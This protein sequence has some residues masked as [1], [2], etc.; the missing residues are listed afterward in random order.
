MLA[1]LQACLVL[2]ALVAASAWSA[3][4][5][6][7]GLPLWA[8]LAGLLLTL[9]PHAPVLALEFLLL[10]LLGRDPQAPRASTRQLIRA[11][12][13]EVL[14]GLRVFGWRQPFGAGRQADVPGRPGRAGVL[15]VHGLVCNR[16]LW[17]PWLVQLWRAGVPCI[18]LSLEPAFGRIETWLPAIDA[19]VLRLQRETGRPPLLV[20]HSMGGLVLR[21][22]L[23]A[24]TDAAAADARVLGLIT[25]GTPHHGTWMAR[26]GLSS[27]ARQMRLGSPWLG[28]LAARESAARRARF[29]CFY[30]HA[31]N[32]VFPAGSA[33]LAGADNRHLAGV[34]HVQML[35]EAPVLA[36]VLRRVAPDRP[37][38]AP[39]AFTS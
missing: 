24:Q 28:A 17:S 6:Q 20:G 30:G 34:A 39:A 32:I 14:T 29:T 23:A 1:R 11:W 5:W 33:T 3:W 7:R 25:V 36:E 8:G 27:N 12:A 13:G 37:A 15:L 38:A 31:D 26:W 10:A 19:A 21:A 16:G 9:A 2:A 35:F 22:W 18:A 4:A